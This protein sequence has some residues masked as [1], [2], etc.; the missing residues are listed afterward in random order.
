MIRH[1]R[2]T[3]TGL[4]LA[5]TALLQGCEPPP[6]ETVQRG[7]RGTGMVEVYNP[8]NL[9]AAAANNTPPAS[10]PVAS[11]DG[12]KASAIYKNVKVLGD[13]SVAEFAQ[14]MV[15]MTNWVSPKQNCAYCHTADFAD[16][17][18]YT[19]VAARRML[20]MTQHINRDWKVHVAGTGVT[21]Y[22]CHRGNNQPANIWTQ[23]PESQKTLAMLGQ[24]V[25]Q[26]QPAPEVNLSALPSDVFTPFLKDAASIRVVGT[27]A[28]PEGN[29][30]S[31]KQTEWTYGLMVHMSQSL[32]V[33][34][35]FCHNTRSFADWEASTP[36]R[37]TAYYGIRMVR[38]LNNEYL[39]SLAD[40]LP[41]ERMGP[42][43]DVPKLNCATCHQGAYKPL[44]GADLLRNH[45]ALTGVRAEAAPQAAAPAASAASQAGS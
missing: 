43:G 6:V 42:N 28:L 40:V 36:Q 30:T 18:L 25:G 13:L 27:S 23:S 39:T 44:Y 37:G 5:A 2:F 16:D 11:P 26:N 15:D 10:S 32:G 29:R 1:I 9:Q 24:W 4:L 17:S 3:A 20:Q 7:Y 8:A 31:I 45:P 12:P 34:C 14:T 33:N 19:K 22:T 41:K 38:E 35:T 21:C